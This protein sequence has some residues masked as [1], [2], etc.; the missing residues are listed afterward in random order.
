MD[1]NKNEVTSNDEQKAK[2]PHENVGSVVVPIATC[3]S[4]TFLGGAF[5]SDPW[6][7]AVAS[8]GLSL[9]GVGVAYLMLRRA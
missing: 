1:I 5:L 2:T 9:M 3:A 7:A 4:L 6:A 8:C